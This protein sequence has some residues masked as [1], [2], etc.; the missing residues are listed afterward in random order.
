MYCRRGLDGL[1][2]CNHVGGILFAVEDF[3]NQGLREHS[4]PVSC[5]SKICSW[6][7]PRNIRIDPKPVDDINITTFRFGKEANKIAKMSLYDP[8][9]PMHR[10]V[11]PESLSML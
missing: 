2:H 3:C 9:A 5:I 1:G 11:N 7:V 8:R 4:E 10:E 6:N